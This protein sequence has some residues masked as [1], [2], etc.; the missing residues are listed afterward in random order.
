MARLSELIRLARPFGPR[1]SESLSATII[2]NISVVLA[3]TLVLSGLLT[4]WQAA[5][6]V[7]TEIGAA[8]SIAEKTVRKVIQE[9]AHDNDPRLQLVRLVRVFDGNRHVKATF[10]EP[11]PIGARISSFVAPAE[12]LPEWFYA[13]MARPPEAIRIP[14][15]ESLKSYG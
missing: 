7:E 5:I 1:K 10:V 13:L 15:P 8:L 4:Y 2:R 9:I 12:E 11:E 14:L 6:K 3:L